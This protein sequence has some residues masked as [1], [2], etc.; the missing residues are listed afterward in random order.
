MRSQLERRPV[1]PV[2]IV[3][4]QH[5]RLPS[6]QLLEPT[7]NSPKGAEALCS[8][9]GAIGSGLE[10]P[11]RGEHPAQLREVLAGEPLEDVRVQR[12]EVLV[13]GVHDEAERK[14]AL[15]LGRVAV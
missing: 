4:R 15:E 10:R 5:Q 12:L 3:E 7:T 9:G 1:G 11:E 6:G 14:L 2:K 8:C 13:D